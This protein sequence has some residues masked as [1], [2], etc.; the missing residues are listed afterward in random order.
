MCTEPGTCTH[1]RTPHLPRPPARPR[2]ALAG[3]P[4]AERRGACECPS[5]ELSH[6]A[7]PGA[8]SPRPS[9]QLSAT[10]Q[11]RG[12]LCYC[13]SLLRSSRLFPLQVTLRPTPAHDPPRTAQPGLGRCSARRELAGTCPALAHWPPLTCPKVGG[14]AGR[15]DE[16]REGV[17]SLVG[18]KNRTGTLARDLV[19]PHPAPP[20]PL[21][22]LIFCLGPLAATAAWPEGDIGR[23]RVR[24]EKTQLF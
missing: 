24:G 9:G 15:G 8:W 16:W 10:A 3:E 21:C 17:R 7:R 11:A 22:I 4:G 19:S 12:C 1:A 18:G 2:S 14:G 5:T 13:E 20:H 6:C 23:A